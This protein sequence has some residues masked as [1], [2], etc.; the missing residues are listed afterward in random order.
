MYN[1]ACYIVSYVVFISLICIFEIYMFFMA[2]YLVPNLRC[3]VV[4]R[5][6]SFLFFSSLSVIELVQKQEQQRAN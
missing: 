5:S 4:A 2:G 6:L 1:K 3:V